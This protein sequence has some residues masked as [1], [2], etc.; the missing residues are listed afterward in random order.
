LK[1]YGRDQ[2][3]CTWATYSSTLVGQWLKYLKKERPKLIIS[4]HLS[5]AKCTTYSKGKNK[6]L[7]QTKKNFKKRDRMNKQRVQSL[8]FFKK[9]RCAWWL[10]A[11]NKF[12]FPLSLALTN[13]ICKIQT[14]KKLQTNKLNDRRLIGFA[15]PKLVA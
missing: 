12:G 8:F 4:E 9:K 11:K 13:W 10:I 15:I 5:W 14:E 2:A 1:S 3:L 6:E 7:S